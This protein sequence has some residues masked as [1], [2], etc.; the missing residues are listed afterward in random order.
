M[1]LQT[2]RGV[3]NSVDPDQ[4]PHSAASDQGLHYLLMP[5]YPIT[6]SAFE[7]FKKVVVFYFYFFFHCALVRRRKSAKFG[8][9]FMQNFLS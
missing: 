2:A 7:I 6:Y 9:D 5:V 3:E 1:S 4:T 8:Q